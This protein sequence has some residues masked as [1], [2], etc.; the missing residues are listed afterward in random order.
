MPRPLDEQGIVE[1]ALLAAKG[2]SQTEIGELLH[3]HQSVVARR[4]KRAEEAGWLRRPK[5]APPS[6]DT[7]RVPPDLLAAAEGKLSHA[8]LRQEL[9]AKL[10]Q[11]GR[12][13]RGLLP[14]AMTIVPALNYKT[15]PKSWDR[16]SVAIG[17]AGAV[18]L[19][20]ILPRVRKMGILWGKTLQALV[21]SVCAAGPGRNGRVRQRV[22]VVPLCG[23][24]IFLSRPHPF[25]LSASNL[26]AR[27]AEELNRAPT[28]QQVDLAVP[29]SIPREFT[30][31]KDL[32]RKFFT[33]VPAYR[34]VFGCP[35][36]SGLIAELDTIVTG[37]GAVSRNCDPWLEARIS[38]EGQE[39]ARWEE[40]IAGDLGGILFA[41]QGLPKA[42]Q[43]EANEMVRGMNE[44]GLGVRLEHLQEC[45]QASE[46]SRGRRPGVLVVAAGRAKAAVILSAVLEGCVNELVI[47][48]D[49]AREFDQLLKE[50]LSRCV[51]PG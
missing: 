44:R 9:E 24:P 35:G 48:D 32:L 2:M 47:D 23:Q 20:G 27:L 7:S 1:A 36:E 39:R 3:T 33:A 43:Q 37:G 40:R 6:L 13:T 50:R 29:A 12:D 34:R 10:G 49:L 16:R 15:D 28:D 45:A 8:K 4:I 14:R 5:P 42:Q 46:N 41:R 30:G 25:A 51:P 19:L 18:R 21:Q 17:Q 26:A 22:E 31:D 38:A 11:L